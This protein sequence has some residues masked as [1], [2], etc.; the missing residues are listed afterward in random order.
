MI[1]CVPRPLRGR[2]LLVLLLALSATVAVPNCP[3]TPE[4]L[5]LVTW[6][7]RLTVHVELSLTVVG[8]ET[9]TVSLTPL[10]PSKPVRTW[11]T[12]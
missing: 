3:L 5:V 10:V 6:I 2:G 9:K 4:P 12:R 8:V 1:R 11:F 7:R